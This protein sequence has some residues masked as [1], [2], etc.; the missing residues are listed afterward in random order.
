MAQSLIKT[1]ADFNTTLTTKVAVGD[2]TATLTSAT[3]DDGVALPTG[4]YVLTLDRK[5]SSKEYIQCT[6]TGT[7]LTNIKTLTRG[8]A[9]ASNGFARTHRKGAEVIISDFAAIKRIT[10]ILDG[11]TDLD[12]GTPLAYDGTATISNANELTTKAYVDGIAIAGSPDATTST[13]GITKM[14]VAPVSAASPI[15]VGDND[16]RVSTQGEN[17]AQ[18]GNNTDITVGTGN[19]FVTQTGLQKNAESYAASSTGNDTYVVTLSPVP[20]SLVNG[21]TIRF[22]PDT[23][24]TGAATLNVN[25]LGALSI[26]TGLS[27]ALA[28]GDIVANQVCEVVYNSTGTVWQ[29]INPASMVLGIVFTNGTTTRAGDTASGDQTI[30][31]GLSKIPKKIRVTVTKTNTTNNGLV[32]STGVYNGTTNSCV[33]GIGEDNGN[34][35]AA[36]QSGNSTTQIVYVPQTQVGANGTQVAVAT[37]DDTNITLTW[38]KTGTVNS[39]SMNILW[40]AEA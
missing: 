31:H 13:K 1:I 38:T 14:S 23:A 19:K 9:V 15:A 34:G 29:L 27:T 24:N 8:T 33:W 37:F 11:T 20:T 12:S 6:L 39:S 32:N 2:T 28:T 40:E 7:A 35:T 10:D 5:T 17:D 22:K 36:S 18:V 3:D 21:M 25:S 26:V 16:G 30:A 4:T